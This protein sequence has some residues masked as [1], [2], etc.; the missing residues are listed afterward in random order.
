MHRGKM[1]S[2]AAAAAATLEAGDR[3]TARDHRLEALMH[4]HLMSLEIVAADRARDGLEPSLSAEFIDAALEI[5][6]DTIVDTCVPLYGEDHDAMLADIIGRLTIYAWTS[7]KVCN[8]CG[9][10]YPPPP[11][12]GKAVELWKAGQ[13]EEAREL[14]E[15]LYEQQRTSTRH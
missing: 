11:D 10:L 2:R 1:T 3:A 13:C 6:C 12:V 4:E 9:K 15:A 7:A 14:Y 5:L 8:C